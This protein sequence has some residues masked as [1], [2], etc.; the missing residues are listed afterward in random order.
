MSHTG[1]SKPEGQTTGISQ[2][3]VSKEIYDTLERMSPDP[4][5]EEL[6]TVKEQTGVP[7]LQTLVY[8]DYA[9][10]YERW[11]RRRTT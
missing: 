1:P 9:R 4:S 5:I 11:Y 8:H 7:V 3:A 6:L 10:E 2:G